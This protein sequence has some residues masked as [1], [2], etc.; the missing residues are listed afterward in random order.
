MNNSAAHTGNGRHIP[1]TGP[2]KRP[3]SIAELADRAMEDLWDDSK[4]FKHYLRVAEKYRK[5]GKECARRGDL[6]GAFVELARA[7]TLVLEKLPMHRDY[8]VKLNANQ[9]QNLALNGQDILDNLSDLKPAIVDRYDKWLQKHPD[10]L[11]QERTP[12]ARTQ[13]IANDESAARAQAQ[14]QRERFQEEERARSEARE[15]QRM[16]AEEAAKWRQQREQM[17]LEDEA[18]RARRKEAAAAAARKA[19]SIPPDYTFSRPPNAHGS[20]STVV[21]AD[22]RPPDEVTRQQQQQQ[23]QMR[24][25]EE[26]I[27]RRQAEQK[28]K[29][30]QE[31]IARR[32][33]EAEEAAHA[34][35]QNLPPPPAYTSDGTPSTA[36]L[37]STASPMFPNYTGSSA[38]TTPASSFFQSTPIEYPS[39][40]PPTRQ[41]SYR[42]PYGTAPTTMPLENPTKYEGDSTDSESIH[43]Y[44]YRR[45]HKP[46]HKTP[47]R[48]VRRCGAV[49]FF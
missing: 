10:G 25:R 35:R 40:H 8:N 15:Q 43:H 5:E 1:K 49:S 26:E 18:E 32:Q 29:Q 6:E 13:K 33:Q 31:G 20:Q 7:A 38:A 28:R 4:D 44:D 14:A 37:A 22:G 36:S 11:D 45:I 24:S 19:A 34:A 41:N 47:T 48:T 12:N 46:E 23:E 21:I 16:A 30:E 17:R 3:S 27:L 39:A 42:D 9:R 2:A